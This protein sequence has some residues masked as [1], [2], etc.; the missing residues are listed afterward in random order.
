MRMR[1]NWRLVDLR[2]RS[3]DRAAAASL[4]LMQ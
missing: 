1:F 2:R 3:L 4:N